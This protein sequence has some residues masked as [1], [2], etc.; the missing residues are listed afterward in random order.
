MFVH[1]GALRFGKIEPGQL[2]GCDRQLEFCLY[3]ETST[4]A[5]MTHPRF[6][7]LRGYMSV[8]FA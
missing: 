3:G 4:M 5:W 8:L 7:L 1:H 6:S 2:H